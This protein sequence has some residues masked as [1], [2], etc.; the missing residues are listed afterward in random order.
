[1]G[2]EIDIPILWEKTVRS[3]DKMRDMVEVKFQQVLSQTAQAEKIV[4]SDLKLF[5]DAATALRAANT[6][7]AGLLNTDKV[8]GQVSV[9]A[10]IERETLEEEWSSG[11]NNS[12]G[13]QGTEGEE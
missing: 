1:M 13:N 10:N 6:T 9:D 3:A 11:Q 7:L 12:E 2:Q 4:S 5:T 8:L